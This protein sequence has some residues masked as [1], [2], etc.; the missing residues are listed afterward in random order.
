MEYPPRGKTYLSCYCLAFPYRTVLTEPEAVLEQ[1]SECSLLLLTSPHI[2][3]TKNRII[4]V[5]KW[6]DKWDILV[7]IF[8]CFSSIW[9]TDLAGKGLDAHA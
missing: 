4:V 2:S 7:L 1:Q 5:W 3:P 6:G 9:G 8:E